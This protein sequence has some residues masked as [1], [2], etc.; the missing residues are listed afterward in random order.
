MPSSF[1]C[2]GRSCKFNFSCS[3]SVIAI[4]LTT[5]FASGCGQGTSSRTPVIGN[6]AVVVL[7]S[8]TANDQLVQFPLTLNNLTLTSQSGTVV[9]LFSS[10]VSAEFI[11]LN[12]TIEPIAT[13]T[14]PQD[15][16]TSATAT[17]GGT[18]PVCVGLQSPP[19]SFLIDGAINGPGTPSVTVNLPAPIEVTGTAMGLVLNLQVSQSAPFSGGCAQNFSLPVA[20]SPVFNLT[21]MVIAAQPTNSANGKALGLE[22][23]VASINEAGTGFTVTGTT[24]YW[25]GDSSTWQVNT[26]SSTV[27]QGI[28]S[29]SGLNTGMP[30]D[31]DLALQSDG[32]LM[33]TRIAV[34]NTNTTN[35][36]LSGGQIIQP[37]FAQPD[38]YG[39]GN[40]TVGAISSMSDIFGNENATSQISGQFT[41]L[42]DLPF[43]ATF[44]TANIVSGQNILFT[45]NAALVDGFPP[46][47]LPT[48]TMTLIPQTINGTVSA[49]STS[50]NFTTYTV[51]LA[52]YDPFAE[53]AQLPDQPP[54]T[55]PNTVTVYADNN[56]QMLNSG[57]VNVGGVFRF[58]GLIF[59]NNGTLSMDC[60]QVNDG[61]A[62]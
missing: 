39:L 31:M 30:V 20:A 56:A 11:H 10:P 22:G 19:I 38:V 57:S 50:G 59:D 41:N 45:S 15:S 23:T 17:Y 46:L 26:N 49:I 54:I 5:V 8:S 40:Q 43:V 25:N 3:L 48:A 1:S 6:T 13:A 37:D 14:I 62:E 44:N 51:T 61:V 55:S 32:T 24:G 36:A 58:Y 16:Y 29:V 7:A 34:Y 53:L 12:G 35:L 42:Q 28:S 9:T 21:P 18:A 33:A 2:L 52:S 47:P 27:F 4:A 60:A